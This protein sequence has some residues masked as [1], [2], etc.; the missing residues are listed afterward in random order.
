MPH[1]LCERVGLKS[2]MHQAV[3]YQRIKDTYRCIPLPLITAAA[4]AV[5]SWMHLH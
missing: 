5:S 3:G 4:A 2:A 1:L